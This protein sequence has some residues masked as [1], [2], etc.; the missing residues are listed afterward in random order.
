MFNNDSYYDSNSNITK[1][2]KKLDDFTKNDF[3]IENGEC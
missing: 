3:F 2:R 1:I